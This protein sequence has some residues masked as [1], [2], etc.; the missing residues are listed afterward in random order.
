MLHLFFITIMHVYVCYLS[1][2]T[3]T[4][5]NTVN[6]NV[7]SHHIY[8]KCNTIHRQRTLLRRVPT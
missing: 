2:S 6:N 1:L 8:A 4:S 5:A 3:N 7:Y